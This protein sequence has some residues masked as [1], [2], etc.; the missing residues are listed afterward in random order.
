MS[1]Q[2]KKNKKAAV[3]DAGVDGE[4]T[5]RNNKAACPQSTQELADPH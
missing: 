1:V 5:K 4:R 2:E 3:G